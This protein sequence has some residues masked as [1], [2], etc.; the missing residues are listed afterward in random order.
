MCVCVAE[1]MRVPIYQYSRVLLQRRSDLLWGWNIPYSAAERIFY[2]Q[3][4][5]SSRIVII[6][7]EKEREK[8]SKEG[9]G[10]GGTILKT[11]FFSFC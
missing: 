7:G 11:T 3:T 10:E 9:G 2:L 5:G 8:G 4:F 6:M 1:C